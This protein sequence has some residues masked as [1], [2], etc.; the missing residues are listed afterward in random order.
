M[1]I[2]AFDSITAQEALSLTASDVVEFQG[3]PAR[4]AS[5]S[6]NGPAADLPTVTVTF[7]GHSVTFG[8]A[9]A[10]VSTQQALRFSDGSALRIGGD[11]GEGLVGGPGDDALFGGEGDDTL[12]AGAGDDLVQGNQGDDS[13]TGGAGSDTLLGGQG[14][15]RILAGG[16]AR[17]EKPDFAQGNLGDDTIQ[18]GT[19][20][21]TLLGG[22]GADRIDGGDGSDLLNGNRGD[23]VLIAH[24]A[25]RL[26]GED[27][28]DTLTA[29][30]RDCVLTGGA[31]ADQFIFDF[32]G[33]ATLTAFNG[34]VADFALEDRLVVRGELL[35]TGGP[36]LTAT[37][38]ASALALA[39]TL[40][41][42]D[43][44]SV[45]IHVGEDIYAF[46][47]AAPGMDADVAIWLVGRTVTLFSAPILS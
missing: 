33:P 26:L 15:D 6:Y 2:F 36:E 39:N 31:G 16:S 43:A 7:A 41:R 5:V 47:S 8:V 19:G 12:Q 10:E 9:V 34:V 11:S 25:S 42:A 3:G 14:N 30:G 20:S 4:L 13:I 27:G 17:D 29:L 45:A 23:D 44:E 22:Q 35:F 38:F 40:F 37:D 1:T 46:F 18:G 24:G 28:A 21:D 32:A